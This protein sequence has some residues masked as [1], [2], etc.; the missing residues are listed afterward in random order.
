MKRVFITG[1]TRGIGKEI[2]LSF[3][4]MT[5]YEI[6]V[7]G[8]SSREPEFV[9]SS[10]RFSY[11]SFDLSEFE[12]IDRLSDFVISEEIDIFVNNAGIYSSS[13]SASILLVNYVSPILALE[14]IVPYLKEKS[15]SLVNINSLAGIYPNANEAKYCSTKFG[16]DGYIKSLQSDFSSSLN[17]IQYYLGAT[18]TDMT[19]G[20]PNYENLI[21]PR[22][23]SESLVRDLQDNSFTTVSK[24]IKRKK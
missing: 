17:I 9:K 10:D 1:S 2:A 15:G 18:K 13:D 16:M 24:I 6:V 23:F 3:F 12:Y 14:K 5:D 4:R 20:R 11:F 21:D 22:E 19:I 7:H 8:S